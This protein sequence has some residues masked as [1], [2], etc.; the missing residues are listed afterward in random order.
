MKINLLGE[1]TS[2]IKRIRRIHLMKLSSFE[3]DGDGR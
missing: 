3:K 2:E 1:D